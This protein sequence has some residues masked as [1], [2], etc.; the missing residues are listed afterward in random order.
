MPTTFLSILNCL[1][2]S[3]LATCTLFHQG[4]SAEAAAHFLITFAM[5]SDL[6]V[7][8][9]PGGDTCNLP[10]IEASASEVTD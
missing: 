8:V 1:G 3:I 5:A 10:S 7:K 9:R 2:C 4:V 6:W